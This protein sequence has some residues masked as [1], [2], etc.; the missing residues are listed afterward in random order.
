MHHPKT[1]AT[2]LTLAEVTTQ[3]K[4]WRSNKTTGGRIPESLWEQVAKLLSSKSYKTTNIGIALGI[5]SKQLRDKFPGHFKSKSTAA[6]AK[7][8]KHAPFVQAP[9]DALLMPS[10]S[11]AQLVIE[12]NNGTKLIFSAV[13]QEQFSMLIKT[14]M[15]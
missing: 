3:F 6:S 7:L 11:S 2:P 4:R 12:R 10:Q 15:E 8:N 1:H 9:L 5:S 13:N 14:F